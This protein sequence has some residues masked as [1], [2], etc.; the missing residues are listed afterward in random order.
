MSSILDKFKSR[1]D[2]QVRTQYARQRPTAPEPQ[3]GA[4]LGLGLDA[5]GRP[6]VAGFVDGEDGPKDSV[7]FVDSAS[8]KP[9]RADTP[10]TD[11]QRAGIDALLQLARAGS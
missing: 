2:E 6:I 9:P 11:A 3:P 10:L 7:T 1:A 5:Y 8:Y 4:G